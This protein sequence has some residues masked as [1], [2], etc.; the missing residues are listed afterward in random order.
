MTKPKLTD[1][2]AKKIL[3]GWP[4]RANSLWKP[5]MDGGYW[6]RA[7]PKD[8]SAPAPIIR[9]PGSSSF[10]TQPDGMWM[11]LCAKKYCDVVAIEVC[12]TIQNLNDKRSRYLATNSSLLVCC[13]IGWLSEKIA[14]N[15]GG[16]K[17]RYEALGSFGA[18]STF[19]VSLP[20]RFMRVLYAIP[21]RQY[22]KWCANHVPTG[23]KFFCK[24][25]SLSAYNG[26]KMQAF[27]RQMSI[28]SQFYTDPK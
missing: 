3:L 17:R 4:R 10:S 11:C 15:G 1:G 6:M 21:G 20:I 28:K 9:A 8:G 19:D 26:Q 22:D 24:H 7:Q 27:L 5:P 2:Q 23:Y 25:S 14:T 13:Q 16:E 18:E 12:G